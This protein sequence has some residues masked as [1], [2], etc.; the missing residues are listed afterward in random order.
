MP[1]WLV[2]A[3]SAAFVVSFGVYARL[4]ARLR[5]GA[6][7]A[8]ADRYAPLDLAVVLGLMALSLNALIITASKSDREIGPEQLW[9]GLA[10]Y[11][12]G[13]LIILALLVFRHIPV[14]AQFGFGAVKPGRVLAI[15]L[16]LIA[17]AFPALMLAGG[18]VQLL[19]G[20][21]AQPQE[22]VEYFRQSLA[23]SDT[24][25]QLAVVFLASMVAP[26]AEEFIFRGYI[27]GVLKKFAGIAPAMLVTSVLFSAIHANLAA[28][29]PLFLLAVALNVAYEVTGSLLV[30]MTM[31]AIFNATQLAFI[32][33]L[34]RATP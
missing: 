22:I 31:H 2:I 7:N 34:A 28:A 8:P 6:C 21:N 9:A 4:F 13:V 29:A 19:L 25:S 33:L 3:L 1:L 11:A 23:G 26:L 17:A 27:Y 12:V 20:A 16:G 30:P 32:C 18:I 14:A 10:T 24:A 5:A 15:A